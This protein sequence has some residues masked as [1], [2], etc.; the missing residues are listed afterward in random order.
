MNKNQ[1][2][3]AICCCLASLCLSIVAVVLSCIAFWSACNMKYD[4]GNAIL[5]AFSIIVTILIGSVTILIAWQVYNHFVAKDEVK[6]M[7]EKETAVIASDIWNVFDCH[8]KAQQDECHLIT[9]D[10]KDYERINVYMQSI[11][12]AKLCKI[13]S[14]KNFSINYAMERF[15]DY[16]EW[17]KDNAEFHILKG[18]KSEYEYICQDLSNKYIDELRH[19]ISKAQEVNE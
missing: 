2:T 11:E 12:K 4:E 8:Q 5:S 6:N 1:N 18:K 17:A 7:I 14:L 13:E 19:Y 15:H 9:N 3:L 10:V 16:Y